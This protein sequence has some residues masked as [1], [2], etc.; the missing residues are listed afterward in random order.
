MLGLT[1]FPMC[2]NEK[3]VFEKLKSHCVLGTLTSFLPPVSAVC[4]CH[5]ISQNTKILPE[6]L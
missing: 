2:L 1:A 3:V 5:C 6:P 4:P